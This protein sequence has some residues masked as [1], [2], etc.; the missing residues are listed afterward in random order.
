V[1]D[2]T[3]RVVGERRLA[4]L[5]DLGA[6]AGSARSVTEACSLVVAALQRAE[7]DVPFA[8]IYLRRG[9]HLA[10]AAASPPGVPLSALATGPDGWPAEEAAAA[11]AAVRV[12]DVASRFADLP[13]G[14]W[15][16]GPAQA[17]VLPLTGEAGGPA[18]G[19]IVLAASSGRV[20]DDGYEAFLA[21]VAQQTASLINGAIAY[22]AQQQRAEDLAELDRAK[23]AFFSNISHEFRTPLTL[24]MGP[25][26]ELRASRSR[27]AWAARWWT[28]T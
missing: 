28:C 11:E 3:E 4:V 23:T 20:L 24:I 17:V 14:G 21:L 26:A 27:L 6:Q 8:A 19:A 12:D 2:T 25:L 13:S 16:T 15:R 5:H 10:V 22:E 9:Q 1:S 18:A 7:K